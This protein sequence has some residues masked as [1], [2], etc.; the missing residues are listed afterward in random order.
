MSLN[1]TKVLNGPVTMVCYGLVEEAETEVLRVEGLK[2]DTLTLN[3]EDVEEE[4]EDSTTDLIGRKGN[5]EFS[6]SELD[7]T[8]LAKVNDDLTKV[9]FEFPGKVKKV[10]FTKPASL[11]EGY[12]WMVRPKVDAGKTKIVVNKTVMGDN[13]P[14]TLPAI[15]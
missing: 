8:D 3:V 10:V 5:G 4:L 13:W 6:H 15:T 9:E 14:F 12:G 1:K 11:S 2:K 7:L